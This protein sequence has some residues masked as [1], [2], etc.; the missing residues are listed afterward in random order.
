MA[1][2]INKT[3]LPMSMSSRK[4]CFWRMCEPLIPNKQVLTLQ[5]AVLIRQ[6]L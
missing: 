5:L 3:A 6:L 1:C 4:A 2:L